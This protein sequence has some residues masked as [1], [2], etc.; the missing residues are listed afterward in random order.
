LDTKEFQLLELSFFKIEY[1]KKNINLI[2]IIK[3]SIY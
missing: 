1:L 3:G 2:I